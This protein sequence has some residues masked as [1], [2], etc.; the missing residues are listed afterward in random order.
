MSNL[1][2]LLITGLFIS[3]SSVI[4]SLKIWDIYNSCSHSH[5]AGGVRT[6]NLN[7]SL[8]PK[9]VVYWIYHLSMIVAF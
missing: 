9:I 3:S 8:T 4:T 6:M 7:Y 1:Q 5:L 2:Y